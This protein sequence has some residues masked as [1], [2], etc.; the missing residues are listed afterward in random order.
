MAARPSTF[1]ESFPHLWQAE[2]LD[3]P[4]LI[5]PARQYVYPQAVEE[6]ERGAL[7]LLLRKEP[8]AT[9]VMMTFA[10][11]FADPSLPYGLWSCPNPQQL[12]AAAGGYVYIVEADRPEQWMQVP[13][14]PV[15][16][17][18]SA[19]EPNLLLFTGFHSVWALGAGGRAWET[20][21][22]S[23]EGLR[24]TEI[25]AHELR[26]FGWDLMTDTE[27]AFTVNLA[28]GS[29]TGGAGPDSGPGFGPGSGPGSE[30]G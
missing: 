19:M 5:S 16:S 30:L 14:R 1:D 17:V 22:L 6:V 25:T 4:P 2:I 15:V 3:R 12:C 26:G 27:V 28:N 24:V 29:H 20:G 18:H 13:Y 23:W 10:L 8:G 7:Q 9:A 11:G 21:R